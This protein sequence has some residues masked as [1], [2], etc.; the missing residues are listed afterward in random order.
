MSAWTANPNGRTDAGSLYVF[1]GDIGAGLP[2]LY[3]INGEN[4]GDH[5]GGC[6][7]G[8]DSVGDLN[9]DGYDDIMAVAPGA[10]P[11]G[12]SYAGSVYVYSGRDGSLLY[13]IDGHE[14]YEYL[15]G[16]AVFLL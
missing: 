5:L 8:I 6:C 9:G 16:S 10:S 1:S 4:P 12:M 3:R 14:P 7:A 11:E 2:L 13:R 15:G